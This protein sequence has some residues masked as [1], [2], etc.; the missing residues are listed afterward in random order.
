MLSAASDCASSSSRTCSR[1]TALSTAC[2]QPGSPLR[3]FAVANGF[4]QQLAQRH[5]RKEIA[6]DIEDL[7][8]ERLA[9][10]LQFAQQPFVD[11]AFARL[12]GDQVPQVADLRLADAV[13]T[14]E[15]LLQPVGI[16]GQVVVDHQVRALQVDAFAGGIGGQQIV[17]TGIV[18]ELVF[19]RRAAYR[20]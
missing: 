18:A 17:D 8:V 3:L 16:P 9:L 14:A 12:A 4:H 7:A 2:F 20:G 15:T 19:D 6:Q 1:S 11:V 5:L 10:R 13:N